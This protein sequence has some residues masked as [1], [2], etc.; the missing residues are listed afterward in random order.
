MSR[1]FEP[2][3]G[4]AISVSHIFGIL[5]RRYKMV[6][7]LTLFGVAVGALL[8]YRDPSTYQATAVFRLAGERRALTGGIES[9]TPELGRTAD[10]LTSLTQLVYS[11]SVMG[12]VVDSL[13][14]RLRSETPEYGVGRVEGVLV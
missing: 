11:R 6:V 9:P 14:L 1:G 8:A 7:G 12:A 5:R 10:P 2:Q 13:G 4:G 3:G